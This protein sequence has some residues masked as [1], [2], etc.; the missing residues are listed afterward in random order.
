[1]RASSVTRPG[2]NKP[3]SKLLSGPAGQH[4]GMRLPAN[5]YQ[6]LLSQHFT[7]YCF[8]LHK[9]PQTSIAL[10]NLDPINNLPS[11]EEKSQPPEFLLQ[12]LEIYHSRGR[13]R[14]LLCLSAGEEMQIP[15]G[16]QGESV[17]LD[18]Q[19]PSESPQRPALGCALLLCPGAVAVLPASEKEQEQ[20]EEK[21]AF[22]SR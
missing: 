5:P 7:H 19:R 12:G 3:N 10:P 6:Y 15:A 4:A 11:A 20:E 2:N 13:G 1:M 17:D 22:V 9:D 8:R 18:P 14:V 16:A 21:R